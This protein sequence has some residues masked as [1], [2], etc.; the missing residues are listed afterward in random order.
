MQFLV[1]GLDGKDAEAI[2]RRLK[3]RENHIRVGDQLVKD[4]NVWF[5]AAIL[6]EKAYMAGSAFL[7]ILKMKLLYING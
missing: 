6:N 4:G 3:V 1:V 2:Q 7:L 5:G